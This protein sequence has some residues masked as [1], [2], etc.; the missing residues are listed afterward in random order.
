MSDH[1]IALLAVAVMAAGIA[2][3]FWAQDR[4]NP[5]S[6][7]LAMTMLAVTLLLLT[8]TLLPQAGN[9]SA[10]RQQCAGE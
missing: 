7:A 6:R 8:G 5:S 4:D 1:A 2:F 10:L 3:I 9:S